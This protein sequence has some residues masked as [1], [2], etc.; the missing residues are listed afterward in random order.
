MHMRQTQDRPTVIQEKQK[1]AA[2]SAPIMPE[3]D[4]SAPA[5][6][7]YCED[8]HDLSTI[9]IGCREIVAPAHVILPE[10][11]KSEL[12]PPAGRKKA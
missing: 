5:H 12:T 4:F 6:Q 11:L 8:P 2:P 9:Q 3:T 7:I 10:K 1:A